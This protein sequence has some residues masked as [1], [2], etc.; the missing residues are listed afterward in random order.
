MHGRVFSDEV[1]VPRGS[2]VNPFFRPPQPTETVAQALCRARSS[3]QV[4][5]PTRP[6]QT[7]KCSGGLLHP[8]QAPRH[9]LR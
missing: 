8:G 2:V 5:R 7:L 4:V 3:E 6:S 1:A 9:S